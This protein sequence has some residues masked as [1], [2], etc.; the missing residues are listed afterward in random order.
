MRE[1]IELFLDHHPA[2][3]S[4]ARQISDSDRLIDLL[5]LGDAAIAVG[6]AGHDLQVSTGQ[7]E[8]VPGITKKAGRK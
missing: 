7:N 1:V 4:A 6:K 5:E 2:Y 3:S 8:H